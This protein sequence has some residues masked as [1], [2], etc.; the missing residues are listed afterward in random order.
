[1]VACGIIAWSDRFKKN[2]FLFK[3]CEFTLFSSV[4]VCFHLKLIFQTFAAFEESCSRKMH[5]FIVCLLLPLICCYPYCLIWE[6]YCVPSLIHQTLPLFLQVSFQTDFSFSFSFFVLRATPSAYGSSQTSGQ[7]GAAA[8]GLHHSHSTARSEP[9]LPPT[10]QSV[11]ML[12]LYS[13]SRARDQT[14]ILMDTSQVLNPLSHNR[15]SQTDFLTEA[16]NL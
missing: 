12:D 10:L 2:F 6:A 14:H 4:L 3:I 8:A 9:H 11:A 1:M 5:P 13:L 7:I 15:N 16:L